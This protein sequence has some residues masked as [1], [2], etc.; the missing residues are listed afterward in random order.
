[1]EGFCDPDQL[2]LQHVIPVTVDRL[3][4]CHGA[5]PATPGH[6]VNISD[7]EKIM[8]LWLLALALVFATAGPALDALPDSRQPALAI[9][10]AVLAAH[11]S[12]LGRPGLR[13]DLLAMGLIGTAR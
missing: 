12:H 9:N 7:A 8:W 2:F 5:I 10:R 6:R 11:R 4:C 1:V 13:G 3:L